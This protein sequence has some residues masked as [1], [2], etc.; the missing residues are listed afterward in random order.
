MTYGKRGREKRKQ[1]IED[2]SFVLFKQGH[3]KHHRP[4][5]GTASAQERAVHNSHS[6]KR[7]NWRTN[8]KSDGTGIWMMGDTSAKHEL[9]LFISHSSHTYF[10]SRRQQMYKDIKYIFNIIR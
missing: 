2:D 3:R 10:C 7:C 8:G 5:T 4:C 1:R 6:D 9:L